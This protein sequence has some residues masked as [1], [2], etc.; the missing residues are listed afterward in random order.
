MQNLTVNAE[1]LPA[2]SPKLKVWCPG[3]HFNTVV[4]IERLCCW[5][6]GVCALMAPQFALL[7]QS[8]KYNFPVSVQEISLFLGI[9]YRHYKHG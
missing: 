8:L 4:T 9:L 1:S 3:R 2:H 5:C 6:C 7:F